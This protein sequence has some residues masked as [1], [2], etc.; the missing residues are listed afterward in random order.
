MHVNR[1]FFRFFFIWTDKLQTMW[2]KYTYHDYT[3]KTS[4][5]DKN[6]TY[7]FR[8]HN[9]QISISISP[10]IRS[11]SFCTSPF[12]CWYVNE[13]H[14]CTKNFNVLN[15]LSQFVSGNYSGNWELLRNSS[16]SFILH[17]FQCFVQLRTDQRHLRLFCVRNFYSH[18]PFHTGETDGVATI[19]NILCLILLYFLHKY[20]V[21]I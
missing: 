19:P 18:L 12:G 11:V 7:S 15:M 6:L 1:F 3:L 20:F 5:L 2:V 4:V 9:F 8:G 17:F 21:N 14:N 16:F 10:L 13:S